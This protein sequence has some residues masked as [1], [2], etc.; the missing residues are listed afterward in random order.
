MSKF[1]KD[2]EALLFALLRE[3]SKYGLSY[4]EVKGAL[5]K[6]QRSLKEWFEAMFRIVKRTYGDD[7]SEYIVQR[8]NRDTLGGK[9]IWETTS[10]YESEL[11]ARGRIASLIA[12]RLAST[13]VE[14]EII[15]Y[16]GE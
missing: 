4:T 3:E 14:E 10:T 6:D 13:L 15:K 7:K 12:D 11:D 16:K 9:Y 5:K 8:L 2:N 1:K